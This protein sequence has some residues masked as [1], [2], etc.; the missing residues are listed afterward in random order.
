MRPC[1]T[2]GAQSDKWAR[3]FLA[4]EQSGEKRFREQ[5]RVKS[6]VRP[7]SAGAGSTGDPPA[8]GRQKAKVRIK[9]HVLR[10][11]LLFTFAFVRSTSPALSGY[12]IGKAHIVIIEVF[13]A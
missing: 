4:L 3:F 13:S 5:L 6:S 9:S 7:L 8:A 11:F 2:C 10:P 1:G 12:S